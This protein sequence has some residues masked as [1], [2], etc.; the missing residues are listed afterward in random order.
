MIEKFSTKKISR[1]KHKLSM[2]NV[3]NRSSVFSYVFSLNSIDRIV[4]FLQDIDQYQFG[5]YECR[6]ENILGQ[7]SDFIYI[8]QSEETTI[9]FFKHLIFLVVSPNRKMKEKVYAE[10][11]NR[12][13]RTA[14]LPNKSPK[15][16]KD[17]PSNNSLR[18]SHLESNE[19]LFSYSIRQTFSSW[20]LLILSI[21]WI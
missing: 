19:I 6:G 14:F 12:N 7:K 2:N 16:K 17:Q 21:Y 20:Y 18:I 13:G 10:E 15:R 11:I 4:D 1:L 9:F 3:H 5:R 8:E